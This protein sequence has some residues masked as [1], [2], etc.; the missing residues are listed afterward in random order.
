[1]Y[2][3]TDIPDWC[4]VEAGD[5]Y[6]PAL[7]PSPDLYRT[8]YS[9]SPLQYAERVCTPLLLR[10]GGDDRRVPPTQGK[11]YYHLLRSMEKEVECLWFE[12]NGHALDKVEAET[13]GWEKSLQWF[14]KWRGTEQ[15]REV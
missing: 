6:I 2:S 5:T 11:E 1:M 3:T 4:V 13:I 10:L 7:L 9:C 15:A 14:E 12:G 8:L